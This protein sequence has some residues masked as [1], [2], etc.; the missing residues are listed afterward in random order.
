MRT[1]HKENNGKTR[2]LREGPDCRIISP[3]GAALRPLCRWFW[4]LCRPAG[5]GASAVCRIFVFQVDCSRIF[6]AMQ[7]PSRRRDR[8]TRPLPGPRFLASCALFLPHRHQGPVELRPQNQHVG[9]HVEPDHQ[10]H[11]RADGPVEQGVV[12]EVF[13]LRAIH[14]ARAARVPGQRSRQGRRA[15]WARA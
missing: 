14:A 3:C 1:R 11:H 15:S 5:V 10:H 2:P 12:G 13:Q 8:K 4:H 7:V 6:P 9:G